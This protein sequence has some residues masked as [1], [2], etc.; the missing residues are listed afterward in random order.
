MG[1]VL[2]SVGPI[3]QSMG[4]A[5]TALPLDSMGAMHWN[6]ASMTGLPVSCIGFSMSAFSSELHLGSSDGMGHSGRTSSDTDINPMPAFGF[7]YSAKDS[8]W[9]IGGGGFA[10]A[11]FGV[12]YPADPKNPILGGPRGF[13]ALYSSYQMMQVNLAIARKVTDRL[14]LGIAP[15]INW[16]QLAVDPFPAHPPGDN[17]R[18]MNAAHADSAWGL[19]MQVGIYYEMNNCWKLGASYKTPQ[20]MQE[21][22][23][24]SVHSDGRAE[25][26]HFKM[27]YPSIT[28]L[29]LGYT[30]FKY[31]DFAFDARY[32]DYENTDG[33]SE[34]GF[35]DHGQVKGFGWSSIWAFALGAQFHL[36]D[37]LK[38][39]FGY[40]YNDNAVPS[41]VGFYNIPAPAIIQ[42][43]LSTG[44]SWDMPGGMM[45]AF[46]YTHGFHNHIESEWVDPGNGPVHRGTNV[47]SSMATH[48][49]TAALYKKY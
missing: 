18:Y 49:V 41:S 42:H 28:S 24:N 3:N 31:V 1:H 4:G 36:T 10:V 12:D 27:D 14:S 22:G 11:G 25:T 2:E 16:T 37:Q 34:T 39:R 40:G 45:V 5:G 17:H 44:F 46:A 8:P 9:S 13:G 30:G 23:W 21:Y 19:G 48:N 29:G 6:S 38:W 7:H 20:W 32:I 35:G 33:F 43:H 26:V 15:T 47:T